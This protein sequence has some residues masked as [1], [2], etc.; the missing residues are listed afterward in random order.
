ML[1]YDV[2][3]HSASGSAA[4]FIYQF[5]R[6][7]KH[8][9]YSERGSI[10]GI[11]TLDDVAIQNDNGLVVYEQDK[12][13]IGS[14]NPISNR[15]RGLWK[16]LK[17]W[18][19]ELTDN[20]FDLGQ[21]Q[22][23]LVTN[24]SISG[25][26]AS[27]LMVPF[28]GRDEAWVAEVLK[29]IKDAGQYPTDDLKEYVSIVL[30]QDDTFLAALLRR[31]LVIDATTGGDGAALEEDLKARIHL[32]DNAAPEIIKGLRGWLEDIVMDSW[33]NGRDAIV[34]RECF[35]EQLR[36]LQSIWQGGKLFREIAA[37]LVPVKDEDRKAHA[38]DRFVEQ[39]LWIGV[40]EG[41]EQLL[42]AIDEY[43]KS[44]TERTRLGQAGNIPPQEFRFFDA[45]LVRRWKQIFNLHAGNCQ[46][47]VGAELQRA[48]RVIFAETMNHRESL[49]GQDT[50]EP[51]L[52]TG[53]YHQ[54][55]NEPKEGPQVGWHPQYK[56]R[57]VVRGDDA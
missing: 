28:G 34:S 9:A 7:L 23:H 26:V 18:T 11:E 16:S 37:E 46:G 47:D 53:A 13:S 44:K 51:Y 12:H 48:G 5:E 3:S 40:R 8:L 27:K 25:G 22:F 4:G 57:C 2:A 35:S 39:L 1:M 24:T 32:S 45:R 38:K 52:T 19:K 15:S 50:H 36:S 6:A 55:A 14:V 17:I 54:L 20:A 49:A 21:A 33:R 41:D 42:D 30:G 31:I 56:S 10:V 29:L 43:L